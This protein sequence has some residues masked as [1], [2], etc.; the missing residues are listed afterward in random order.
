[1]IYVRCVVFGLF[2]VV[3]SAIVGGMLNLVRR[4][5]SYL[6]TRPSGGFEMSWDLA[7]LLE[8]PYL[9]ILEFIIFAAGFYWEYRRVSN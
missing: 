1:M 3:L 4:I 6:V 2:A 5:I 9:W 8:R 7:A